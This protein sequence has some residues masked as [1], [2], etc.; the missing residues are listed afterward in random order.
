[1]KQ[2]IHGLAAFVLAIAL[3]AF[4]TRPATH[5][6]TGEKWFILSSGNPNVNTNYYMYGD[7]SNSPGCSFALDEKVCAVHLP[8]SADP[9]H[10]GQPDATA[11]NN[12]SIATNNFTTEDSSVQYRKDEE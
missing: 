11:L 6:T 4:T 12:L 9:A 5:Q 3:F 7:G 1:M 10:A 8:E 2:K